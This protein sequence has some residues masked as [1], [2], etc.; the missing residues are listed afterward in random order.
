MTRKIS[1]I[2]LVMLLLLSCNNSKEYSITGTIRGYSDGDTISLGYSADGKD[3]TI[4]DKCIV[5]NEQFCFSG[6]TKGCDIYYIGYNTADEKPQFLLFFLE[7]GNIEIEITDQTVNVKGTPTND[8]VSMVETKLQDYT[9]ELYETQYRLESDSTMSDTEKS[10]LALQAMEAQRDA[11]LYIQDIIRA[12]IESAAG[13][14]FLVQFS[15]LFDDNELISL[16]NDIPHK[17]IKRQNN[18]MYD[19]LK[20]E[21]VERS[22]SNEKRE[23]LY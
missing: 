22:M 20:E 1:S 14:Y 23:M 15:Y 3:Y 12:N 13:L 9:S 11:V 4:T 2:L 18:C 8:L 6:K 10:E 5:K 17:N 16:T 19:M 21:I 7:E